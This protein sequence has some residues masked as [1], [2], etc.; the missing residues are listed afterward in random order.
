MTITYSIDHVST[1]VED[2]S[3]ETAAKS[4][5]TLQSTTTD[6]KT[7][8]VT[9][10]YVLASGDD[11]YKAFVTYTSSI[12]NRASG[13]IRRLSM[14]FSTWATASNSISGIDTKK[15][16]SVQIS[17]QLPSDMTIE[18]ADLD[19]LLGNAY[20]FTYEDV[21]TKVRDTVWLQKL[22]YGVPQVK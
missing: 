3:V 8:N 5:M 22:L 2:V 7:G 20:S 15:P 4:E 14:L 19:K 17:I 13:A 10:T 16:I 6:Q 21:T 9:S 12:Q 11:A 1:S 18:L